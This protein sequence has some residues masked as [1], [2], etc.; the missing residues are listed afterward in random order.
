MA[1][2]LSHGFSVTYF[3]IFL[4]MFFF[5]FT[6]VSSQLYNIN[7]LFNLLDYL[8]AIPE[9]ILYYLAPAVVYLAEIIYYVFTLQFKIPFT[10]FYTPNLL[11][12]HNLNP[13]AVSSIT[14]NAGYIAQT[15]FPH[16]VLFTQ[17]NI[18]IVNEILAVYGIA[19]VI[20]VIPVA[21]IS[22]LGFLTRGEV[23]LAIISFISMQIFIITAMYVPNYSTSTQR[24]MLI[25]LALPNF[26][27]SF[28]NILSD[29]LT[30]LAS[31]IFLVALG[32][33][34][35]LELAFQASYTTSVIDPME[36][37][38]NRI[39]KHLQRIMSF[40]PAM[41]STGA[42]TETNI[43]LG[44]SSS[45]IKKYD[46]LAASYLREM[47]EN[48][49]FRHGEKIEDEKTSMRLQSYV[50][51]LYRTDHQFEGKITAAAARPSTLAIVQNIVPLIIVRV[52]VVVFLAFIILNPEFIMTFLSSIGLFNFPDLI[53]SV[54]LTQPEFR[55][56]LL[57]NILLL[58]LVFS[59]I[60]HFLLVSKKQQVEEKE[61][62][63]VATLVDFQEISDIIAEESGVEIP[64]EK[65]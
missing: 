11:D 64:S 2:T 53:N 17:P 21:L 36:K 16:S 28:G 37:R 61:V 52:I 40:R 3:I 8:I 38:E 59:T 10:T 47:V 6:S 25:N 14:T 31:P 13:G 63:K 45:T 50:N 26:S 20:I 44:S 65:N 62:Q 24:M 18:D 41:K 32:L 23:R 60:V 54:E 35:L 22:A 7:R 29:F 33:Y 1:S 12:W 55:T 57:F 58:I 19:V 42:S 56:V 15:I 30:F 5:V 49:I 4:F 46:L 27:G 9:I 34:I 43:T 48:R 39:Q 51:D